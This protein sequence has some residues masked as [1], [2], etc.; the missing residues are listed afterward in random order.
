LTSLAP[1][2]SDW[3]L[4]AGRL[5]DAA[6][7][8]TANLQFSAISPA[9][10]FGH[11]AASLIATTPAD[12]LMAGDDTIMQVLATVRDEHAAWRGQ[13]T[14]IPAAGR[15]RSCHL[16]VVLKTEEGRGL[17]L[18]GLLI[19]V[20]QPITS[21]QGQAK[22]L[23]PD[24][25]LWTAQSFAEQAARRFDRLD[26]E[27]QPGTL[28]FLG[29]LNTSPLMQT[30]AAMRLADELRDVVRPADLLGRIDA[31]TI[32]LWCDGMDH[33]TGAERAARFCKYLPALLP[34]QTLVS[35]G[36]VTRWPG[37]IDDPATIISRAHQALHIAYAA[38][39]SSRNAAW[40]V[41]QSSMQ[42]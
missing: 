21:I 9:T 33:L 11:Q 19:D 29:F 39:A 38:T 32:G 27:N 22:R 20:T 7:E 14:V 28:L 10:I 26:V 30:P 18:A 40:R 1:E 16:A 2:T 8:L 12:I 13:V 25:G 6:F 37:S 23:D 24:T 34:A 36:L 4:I 41:W 31:T 15:A 35:V 3:L 17:G 42:G 5:A